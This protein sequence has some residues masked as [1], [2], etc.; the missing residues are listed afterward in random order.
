MLTGAI[1]QLGFFDTWNGAIPS[2]DPA[3]L[4]SHPSGNLYIADSEINEIGSVFTG[5]N[6]FQITTD[7]QTVSQIA[8]NN[9]EPTGITYNEFDGFF[10]VSND[11]DHSVTRYDA[12]F[13]SP[14]ASVTTTDD[15]S[16]ADDPE[17]IASDPA[18]GTLYVAN[19]Q[20]G[21][22]HVLVYDSNLNFQTS[23]QISFVT[24]P[25]GIA[26]NSRNGH[27]YV[28]S[29]ADMA[30]FEVTTS[31]Q[32]VNEFDISGFSP[33]PITPQGIA[34]APTSDPN[35]GDAEAVYIADAMIDN[36]ADG[37]I[38]E[39]EIPN[40]APLVDA[41]PDQ[42][43]FLGDSINLIGSIMDDGLPTA[44]VTAN[45]SVVSGPGSVAFGNVNSASTSATFSDAGSY[46]LRLEADDSEL[47]AFDDVQVT[48]LPDSSTQTFYFSLSRTSTLPGLSVSNEDII[49]YDGTNFSKE[50]DGSDVGLSSLRISAFSFVNDNE[51]LMS[52]SSSGTVPG[53]GT[54][55]DDSDIVKFTATQLGE[56]TQGTFE[57]YFDGSDVGLTE[58]SE[59]IDGVKLLADGRLLLSTV[60]TVSVSGIS[61]ARDEDI[62]T[63]T[64]SST[65]SS[66]SGS[67]ELYL[68]FSSV[69]YTQDSDAISI[70]ESGELYISSTSSVSVDGLAAD[71]E[72]VFVFVPSSASS[73]TFLDQLYF[74]GSQFG[75]AAAD[76]LGFDF[77]SSPSSIP[78]VAQDDTFSTAEDTAIQLDVLSDNGNGVDSDPDGTI[79]PS[80]VNA[81]SQPQNGNLVNNLDGTFDYTPNPNFNGSDS[82][83]YTVRDDSGTT[84]NAATVIVNVSAVNDSPQL[85][86]I[87]DVTVVEG[88]T[89]NSVD[90]DDYFS[91]VETNSAQAS[92]AVDSS[93]TGI[94][95][96]IDPVSHVMSISADAGFLG[97]GNVTIR[98]TDTGDGSSGPLTAFD[99]FQVT[100]TE[101][102]DDPLIYF[103]VDKD[104]TINGLS[105][106]NEDVI[107][108]DG[109]SFQI[110]FDGSDVGIRGARI[111]AVSILGNNEILMSFA[112]GE[113]V[114]GLSGTV[115]DSD[116][117]KFVGTQLGTTTTG[118]FEWFIDGSDIGLDSSS[119]DIDAIDALDDGRYIIS[120]T[121]NVTVPAVTARDEDILVFDPTS[122]G[123]ATSGTWDWYVD[124]SD[125][126]ISS[127]DIDAVSQANGTLQL[128]F[129]TEFQVS[130]LQGDDEDIATLTPT[131]LGEVTTGNYDP[132]L[133]FDGDLFGLSASDL[134]AV[135]VVFFE[136]AAAVAE[137]ANQFDDD[138]FEV[139]ARV[140]RV[141]DVDDR[142]KPEELAAIDVT[143]AVE[144]RKQPAVLV[145]QTPIFAK[146]YRDE[147]VW[148]NPSLS[149]SEILR[150][151]V[152]D[153]EFQS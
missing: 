140:K 12:T 139:L 71:D 69:G 51:I 91:D 10:Y 28:V 98:A 102:P 109:T 134:Q 49:R 148:A 119:E 66:T 84:S 76:L 60:G 107:L 38:F 108:F 26:F 42:A 47:S 124:G 122:L 67:W 59:D 138:D 8:T 2:T 54:T 14:L 112:S 56:S 24:D 21:G 143:L 126:Q 27:L 81:T 20:A 36:F 115:E 64:P 75:V 152:D 133:L 96:S 15:L 4:T 116:V 114:P 46:Q 92:F 53:I 153:P 111:D 125:V 22:R 17:G 99:T 5:Q 70:G 118:S 103:T 9:S 135:D 6:V 3:G 63:F 93:F 100:V 79:I 13:S 7:G 52:F 127:E 34:F 57:L 1:N 55:V 37:R 82:F 105:V 131:Q 151:P 117:V 25:E 128:S 144:N 83:T 18:T 62:L 129:Q 150:V 130:N 141:R 90:L 123:A 89:N 16:A 101:T 19:G 146:D 87:P 33:T 147:R 97:S 65:G 113:S 50:F 142:D 149:A 73:G 39:A 72:D 58:S 80:T 78:P 74:D 23:F 106:A 132:N 95:V 43:G 85:S 88:T 35:D 48:I 94:S 31:G 121:G 40:H 68:D 11:D 104:T 29:T 86:G 145:E 110:V 32:L 77:R 61:T 45:W 137:H 44:S 136:S 41:G 30:I 120:T